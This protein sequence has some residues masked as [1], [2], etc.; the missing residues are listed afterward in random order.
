MRHP[1]KIG[2][3]TFQWADNFGALLQAY[4]L[5]TWLTQQGFDVSVVN[6]AP[7][8]LRGRDWLMP[9]RP[10]RRWKKFSIRTGL[11]NAGAD[12]AISKKRMNAFRKKYLA[13]D[14][15]PIFRTKTLAKVKT[16]LLIVGSDQI[17]NPN[18]TCGLQPAYF[19]AFQNDKIK[20][21]IAYGTSFGTDSL[22]AEYEDEFSRL[23]TSVC[24]ISM[25]EKNAAEYVRN[26]F[27]REAVDVV[28]PVL[29]ITGEDWR[30]IEK[31]PREKGY[32]L[33]YMPEYNEE[34]RETASAFARERNLDV[35]ELDYR[36]R[37]MRIPFQTVYSAGPLEFLGYVS[38]AECVFSNSFHGL[39]F[40]ILFHKPFFVWD[41]ALGARLKNLLMN[42][43]LAGRM[44][45]E[46]FMSVAN[47]AIN[48]DETECLLQKKREASK[49][50]LLRNL[51]VPR[52]KNI[53]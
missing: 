43:N 48:W 24:D 6:Y 44:I 49:E 46:N 22:P 31:P 27:Q 35:I 42:T 9:Y 29:L 4:G 45:R 2:I 26:R 52:C 1:E 39:A 34:L 10:E 18:I 38:H 50:F 20:K 36:K 19:G 15:P 13:I 12:W 33:C 23:L 51:E 21:V 30:L 5:Q 17:W 32:V 25:R 37:N 16:D 41:S 28:D 3:L 53:L 14:G 40:S 8:F 11:K 47:Q 7:P